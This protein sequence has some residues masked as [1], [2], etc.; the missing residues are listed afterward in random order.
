[1][2][3]I[4]YLLLG[5]ALGASIVTAVSEDTPAAFGFPIVGLTAPTLL[6][7]FFIMFM[8]GDILSGKAHRERIADV[9]EDCALW[10][11]AHEISEEGRSNALIQVD[12]LN[13]GLRDMAV[14]IKAAATREG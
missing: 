4:P 13:D 3:Y 8:R 9:K 1:M 2:L 7:I 12:R 10:Q 11:K 6:S 14:S 5:G